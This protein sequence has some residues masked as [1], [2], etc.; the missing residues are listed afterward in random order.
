MLA[1]QMEIKVHEIFE[2][3]DVPFEEEYTF[4]DLISSSGRPLRFDFAVFTDDGELDFLIECQGR[5]HYQPVGKYG[6]SKGLHRQRY[7]DDMKK[8]YCLKNHIR[9][10]CIPYFDEGKITYEYIMRAAGY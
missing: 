10:V 2:Q 9:L 4:D 3:F 5:Q 7:N 6:G 8:R 1:S